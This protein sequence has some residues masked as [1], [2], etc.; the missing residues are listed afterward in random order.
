MKGVLFEVVR[1]VVSEVWSEDE[2]DDILDEA[3]V[4]GAYTSLGTYPDAELGAIVATACRRNGLSADDLVRTVGERGFAHLARRAAGLVDR[5][6]GWRPLVSS[7]N[8]VIHPEVEK[9]YPGANAPVFR[10]L[11]VEPLR[12]RYESERHLCHLA[13][14]LLVGAAAWFGETITVTRDRCR[15]DGDTVC[16]LVVE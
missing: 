4:V 7:L 5:F 14:G 9:L 2:W 13:E 12:L 1:E 3:G 10:V 8:D 15:A 16:E 11:G 6:D